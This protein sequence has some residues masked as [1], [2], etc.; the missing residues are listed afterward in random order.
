MMRTAVALGSNLGDRLANSRSA[1]K[2]ILDLPNVKPP[3]LSSA[4]YETD[5]V[6]CEPEAG[7]FLNAVLEFDYEGDP[8]DLLKNLKEIESAL[9]RPPNHPRNI[10]R[11]I[12]IDLLYCG[13]TATDAEE[14]Q[15]PHPRMH[16]RK[17]VL[18]PLADIRP[19]LV[20]PGQTKTVREL[21]AQIGDSGK[22]VHSIDRW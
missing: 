17:F 16:L 10:S 12:D 8:L 18:Q 14:L 15:L 6:G 19:D 7:K 22:V 5:P 13:D 2:A 9:G 21:L 20:L 3:I 4:I 1:R 11:K